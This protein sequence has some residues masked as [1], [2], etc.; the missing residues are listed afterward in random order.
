[1]KRREEKRGEGPGWCD[2]EERLTTA[3]ESHAPC[4]SEVVFLEPLLVNQL[5][6]SDV[7]DGEQERGCHR[8]CEERPGRKAGLVPGATISS[9]NIK[10]ESEG[11]VDECWLWLSPSKHLG[12]EVWRC[13]RGQPTW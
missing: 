3:V 12:V 13:K 11:C 10:R 9:L 4:A 6:R 2:R 1:M 8:L 7:A 5:L